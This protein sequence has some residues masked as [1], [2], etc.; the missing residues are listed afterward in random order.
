[1]SMV[2]NDASPHAEVIKCTLF[3][4]ATQLNIEGVKCLDEWIV[5][6]DPTLMEL[7]A[8]SSPLGI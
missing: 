4:Y 8:Y 7:I 1:M 6:Y 3:S 5:F 2:E